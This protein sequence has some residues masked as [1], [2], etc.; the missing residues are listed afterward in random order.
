M[1]SGSCCFSTSSISAASLSCS[2]FSAPFL[3]TCVD[4]DLAPK[5]GD[6]E[7]VIA[8]HNLMLPFSCRPLIAEFKAL[9]IESEFC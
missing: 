3:S 9:K 6:W 2:F 8:G 5:D 4:C 7:A 1:H